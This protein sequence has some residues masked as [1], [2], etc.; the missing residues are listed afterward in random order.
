MTSFSVV[1]RAISC[2]FFMFFLQN[3]P[4]KKKV[5]NIFVDPYTYATNLLMAY[6]EIL[7]YKITKAGENCTPPPKKRY[8]PVD[9]AFF[10]FSLF[11]KADSNK[12]RFTKKSPISFFL[13]TL[14]AP[15]F[16]CV[17]APM[18]GSAHAGVLPLRCI[19]IVRFQSGQQFLAPPMSGATPLLLPPAVFC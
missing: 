18:T 6:V 7:L 2:V 17:P 8:D 16:P 10:R 9:F 11:S 19:S 1:N 12:N 13:L 3:I 14:S 4:H 5:G 15:T